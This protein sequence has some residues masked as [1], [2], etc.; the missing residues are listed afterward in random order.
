[1]APGTVFGLVLI[2]A[3]VLVVIVSPFLTKIAASSRAYLQPKLDKA[4]FKRRNLRILRVMAV[5]WVVIGAGIAIFGI[6]TGR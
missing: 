3:G 6:M 1:M 4:A 5:A 2:A